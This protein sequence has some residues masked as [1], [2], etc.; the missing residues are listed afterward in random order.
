[1]PTYGP[2]N[3]ATTNF[4]L[5]GVKAATAAELRA[6]ASVLQPSGTPA[7]R[8]PSMW[9]SHPARKIGLSLHP[10]VTSR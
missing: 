10:L 1:M 9:R 8:M 6:L 3:L 5:L 4:N 2:E 7:K